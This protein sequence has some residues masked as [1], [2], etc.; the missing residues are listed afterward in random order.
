MGK[1]FKTADIYYG[2]VEKKRFLRKG[3]PVAHIMARSKEDFVR[4]VSAL[5]KKNKKFRLE[6]LKGGAKVQVYKTKNKKQDVAFVVKALK[7]AKAGRDK[8]K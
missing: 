4:Q 5:K 3:K 7:A 1:F 8:K 6:K 2:K